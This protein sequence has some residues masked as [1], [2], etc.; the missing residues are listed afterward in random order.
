MKLP[1]NVSGSQLVK[2]LVRIGYVVVRQTGS[3][4]RM[5]IYTPTYNPVSVPMHRPI[6][7]GTLDGILENVAKHAGLDRD[8]PLQI[9]HL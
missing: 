6:K 2:A 3:H 5:A 4:V 8:A 7:V 9:L 1:R